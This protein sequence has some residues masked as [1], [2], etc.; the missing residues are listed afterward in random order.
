MAAASITKSY[1]TGRIF[2][3]EGKHGAEHLF[4]N[5]GEGIAG[6]WKIHEWKV[7]AGPTIDERKVDIRPPRVAEEVVRNR[8]A[9]SAGWRASAVQRPLGALITAAF[10]RAFL[11][12]SA[13]VTRG[14]WQIGLKPE[15]MGRVSVASW[16]WVL[17]RWTSSSRRCG[18]RTCGALLAQ[19]GQISS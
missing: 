18:I 13:A 14:T 19:L 1:L 4:D 2:I 11:G 9:P 10:K 16:A 5:E 17:G 3:P 6:R 15:Q 8:F 12:R 7:G